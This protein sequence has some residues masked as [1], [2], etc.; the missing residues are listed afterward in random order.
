MLGS[1]MVQPHPTRSPRCATTRSQRRAK[2]SGASGCF[3]PST[4]RQPSGRREM[5]KGDE[6]DE[7]TFPAP[8]ALPAIVLQCGDR[9][10][11]LFGLDPT[12]LDREPVGVEAQGR[13]QVEIIRPPVPRVTRIAAGYRTWGP[14]RVL[15]L[16]PIVVGVAT[17]DLVGG[18]RRTPEESIGKRGPRHGRDRSGGAGPDALIAAAARSRR[19]LSG[20]VRM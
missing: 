7:P 16:P 17:L 19:T 14:G 10:L 5:V 8:R 6:G 2:R 1:L 9:P 3:P 20:T 18:G 13:E 11:V 12:P 4:G 15:E